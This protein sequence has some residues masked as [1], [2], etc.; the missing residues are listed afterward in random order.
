MQEAAELGTKKIMEEHCST[1]I[2]ITTD[3]TITDIPAEDY[4]EAEARSIR[5]MQATGKPYVVLLN[6]TDPDGAEAQARRAEIEAEY[7]ATC[8]A[9]NCLTMEEPALREILAS[10]LYAFPVTEVQVYLPR[11][12]EALP[13]EHPVKAELYEAMRKSA[14]EISTLR[15]AEPSLAALGT[16]GNVERVEMRA[17]EPGSGI[18][19]CAVIL[20]DALYYQILS[21]R[22]GFPVEDDRALMALLEELAAVKRQYDKVSTALEQVRATGYGIVMPTPDE[23]RLEVPQIVRRGSNYGVRLKASAPS[24]HMLRADIETEIN[25]IVGDE[26]QSK[27]LLQYLLSEYE[28]DTEKLWSSNIFGKSVYE[29]VNEGLSGKLKKMPEEARMKLQATLSRIINE[30][31]SGLLCIIFA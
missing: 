7:G 28:G 24:I 8:L 18:V 17:V 22:S 29:L 4:R 14:G 27:E 3:G 1:G 23:M 16:L 11:W 19:S 30:G 5:D 13:V 26:K 10:L 15:Q 31:S 9:V 6:S 21:E 25:P 20:P 2:V 12:M